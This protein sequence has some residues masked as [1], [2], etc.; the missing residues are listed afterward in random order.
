M[1]RAGS[2]SR[3]QMKSESGEPSP[4][5]QGLRTSSLPGIL[6]IEKPKP[7]TSSLL[8]LQAMKADRTIFFY[9]FH[10]AF[11][12]NIS[13]HLNDSFARCYHY[14]GSDQ[15]SHLFTRTLAPTS[16]GRIPRKKRQECLVCFI[17]EA[18]QYPAVSLVIFCIHTEICSTKKFKLRWN[19]SLV[20]LQSYKIFS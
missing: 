19:S 1:D 16:S 10:Y 13:F 11:F 5:T 17:S 2:A 6:S 9:M 18:Q 20:I 8:E 3:W 4:P 15:L 12:N 14:R 7:Y